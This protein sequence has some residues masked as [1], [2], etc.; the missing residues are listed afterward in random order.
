M[1]AMVALYAAFLCIAITKLSSQTTQNIELRLQ[2]V[3]REQRLFESEA[4]YRKLAHHDTLTGLPNRFALQ[5]ALPQ[6][7]AQ[8]R[9]SEAR[10]ALLYLDLDD[11]KDVNDS[12]GH[13]CGDLLLTEI[14]KRLRSCL[15]HDDLVARMGGDE[16]IVVTSDA[17]PR[18]QV[19]LLALRI[20]GTLAAPL[21]VADEMLSPRVSIGIA[22]FPDDGNDTAQL[23]KHADT[24]L[25][26]AKARGRNGAVFY[27]TVMSAAVTERLYLERALLATLD[28]EALEV[29]YQ[30]LVDLATGAVNGLEALVRWRHADRG[31]IS[32]ATCIATA[33]QC[34]LIDRLGKQVLGIVARQIRQW[35]DDMLP[36][37]PVAI[38]ISPRQLERGH[39]ASL[40][41][42]V[43]EE[44]DIDPSMLQVEITESTLMGNS[45]EQLSGLEALRRMGVQVSIDDFGTGYS[46]LSYLKHLPIDCVKIDRCFIHDMQHDSRDAAIVTAVVAIG[47][48][49]GLRVVAEGVETS[50]QAETLVALGC[51]SAQGYHFH[52][53]LT[54]EQCREL[55]RRLARAER[56]QPTQ[57][58]T[59]LHWAG[60]KA[61]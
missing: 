45:T 27:D 52:R 4:R 26:Q 42:D 17:T 6:R 46:N 22:V 56:P 60:Q 2:S 41:A 40:V 59:S 5:E 54:P 29:V 24:A 8:A 34:G 9:D 13:G 33:E 51:D 38:N 18:E 39:F 1:S 32:P 7:L 37:I 10:V 11:F 25:Y 55:L 19:E 50:H 35:Q 23:M 43:A 57:S 61:V 14:A 58:P 3:H 36:P 16:F 21:A 44:H 30:P 28:S 48:S 49:L 12:R 31:L 15:R 47:H 53:P 20:R